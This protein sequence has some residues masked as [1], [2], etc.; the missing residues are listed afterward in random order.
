M[1]IQ[2]NPIALKDDP[3]C[4]QRLESGRAGS[5]GLDSSRQVLGAL[6]DWSS[7]PAAGEAD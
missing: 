6:K 4:R 1:A 7:F 2:P 3:T 5:D